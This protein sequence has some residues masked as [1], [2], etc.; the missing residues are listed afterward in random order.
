MRRGLQHSC[1]TSGTRVVLLH[2]PKGSAPGDL[3]SAGGMVER[4][5]ERFLVCWKR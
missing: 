2:C 5:W 1:G 4:D 3:L